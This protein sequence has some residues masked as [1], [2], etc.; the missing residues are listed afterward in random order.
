MFG[1]LLIG[2]GA[3]NES[4]SGDLHQISH[5]SLQS[6]LPKSDQTLQREGDGWG[7]RGDGWG[8]RGDGWGGRGWGKRFCEHGGPPLAALTTAGMSLGKL[9][10]LGNFRST[11]AARK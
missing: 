10:V 8:G 2:G 9:S 11:V 1:E 6:H 7:G 5:S 4:R 3:N